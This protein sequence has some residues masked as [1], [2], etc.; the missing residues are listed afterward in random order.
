M[1]LIAISGS[2]KTEWAIVNQTGIIEHAY[3]DGINPY[4]QPRKAISHTIRLQLPE[5][6]FKIKTKNIFFYGAGCSN[7]EKKNTVKASI[8]TQFRIPAVVN[9]DLLGAA[10]SLFL[11]EPGIACIL[12]TGS[13]TCFFDGEEI[14]KN[15][16]SLGFILGD[17]GS[18]A[19]MGKMFLSDC[20][21]G[22][23]PEELVIPFYHKYGIDPDQ[24]LDYVYIKP[25]PNR[26]LSFFSLYLAEQTDHPYVHQLVYSCFKR[27]FERNVK[28]YDYKDYPIR[29]VGST[30]NRFSGILR[31]VAKDSN[32]LIDDIKENSLQGLIQYHTTRKA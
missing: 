26:L 16:K 28:Q 18:G 9:S 29:I 23:A 5:I 21:K 24:V 22:L 25:F 6:F 12:G 19:A 7:D 17:E 8:E 15:V 20:L 31:E 2:T 14:A 27:F 1:K 30:A 13:N 4:F 3:T 32:I 10:R 11:N